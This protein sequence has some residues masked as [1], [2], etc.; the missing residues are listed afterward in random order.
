MAQYRGHAGSA[1]PYSTQP[2]SGATFTNHAAFSS[3]PEVADH[4]RGFYTRSSQLTSDPGIEVKRPDGKE[5]AEDFAY[6][7]PM[8]QNGH[9]KSGDGYG[10]QPTQ[11][12]LSSKEKSFWILRKACAVVVLVVVLSLA[13]GLGLG[14]GLKSNKYAVADTRIKVGD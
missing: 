3:L 5:K 10:A 4:S 14:L 11:E 9:Y 7:I 8:S 6:G 12:S 1:A 13:L 2:V